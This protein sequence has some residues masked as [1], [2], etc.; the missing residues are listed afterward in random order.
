MMILGGIA[1]IGVS[2]YVFMFLIK[3]PTIQ[4]DTE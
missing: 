3:H 1:C 2:G 4:S